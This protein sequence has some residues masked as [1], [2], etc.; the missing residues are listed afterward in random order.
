MITLRML[1]VPEMDARLRDALQE[2]I[3]SKHYPDVKTWPDTRRRLAFH[4]KQL[5]EVAVSGE[6]HSARPEGVDLPA[7]IAELSR[8]IVTRLETTFRD[9][10]PFT[11]V[12][13]A[14]LLVSPSQ[15]GYSLKNNVLMYKF[16]N[17]CRKC[18]TVS[19]T[20]ADFPLPKFLG[21][22]SNDPTNV[23]DIPLVSIPW[24]KM[25]SPQKRSQELGS[26]PPTSG[27]LPSSHVPK[28]LRSETSSPLATPKQSEAAT[29]LNDVPD[30]PVSI[31]LYERTDEDVV[32]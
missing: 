9:V 18:F 7:S 23:P 29:P 2:I 8:R 10:P 25:S 1:V 28:R 22:T 12:R 4:L 11:I 20:T 13:V 16:F 6:K 32:A 31:G 30:L 21:D 27:D 3:I 19:S 15:Q 26:L 17:S 14:E 5:A 24:L